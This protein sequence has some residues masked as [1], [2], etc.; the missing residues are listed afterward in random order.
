M[1][2]RP[3]PPSMTPPTGWRRLRAS[4]TKEAA[5]TTFAVWVLAGAL[6]GMTF[7]LGDVLVRL[8][9]TGWRPSGW[10]WRGHLGAA[11]PLHLSTG[12]VAGLAGWL[13]GRLEPLSG[14]ALAALTAHDRGQ[15]L[16]PSLAAPLAAGAFATIWVRSASFAPPA[17]LAA[18]LALATAAIMAPAAVVLACLL[19][20]WLHGRTRRLRSITAVAGLAVGAAFA[21]VDMTVLVALYPFLHAV[22]ELVTAA[23]WLTSWLLLASVVVERARRPRRIAAAVAVASAA[24]IVFLI[25]GG[26]RWSSAALRHTAKHKAYT[27]RLLAHGQQLAAPAPVVSRRTPH[28]EATRRSMSRLDDRS[29]DACP[30]AWW[31][32][33]GSMAPS[34]LRAAT[35]PHPNIVVFYV[36]TLRYDVATDPRVMPNVARFSRQSL[37]FTRAYATGS[38]TRSSLPAM[39]RG[40]YDF[41]LDDRHTLMRAAREHGL[42]TAVAIGKSPKVWLAKHIPHFKFDE[43][44]EADDADPDRKVW[45]YGANRPTTARLVDD[46]LAWLTRP[47]RKRFLLWQFHYDLHGWKEMND[48]EVQRRA[49]MHAIPRFASEEQWRYRVVAA[50]I[51]AEF[52]RFLREL[53]RTGLADETVVV[54]LADHGEG[55]GYQGFWLHAVFLWEGMV[56]VPL[57]VRVP[58]LEG[59]RV[60]TPVSVI[61]VAPTLVRMLDPGA[62]LLPY[63]GEDLL[64]QL[65]PEPPAR[66]YPL[67]MRSMVK[68]QVARLGVVAPDGRRKLVLPVESAQPELY[69]LGARLPD[70]LD[71]AER[72]PEVVDRLMPVVLEGAMNPQTR[73]KHQRCQRAAEPAPEP[74]TLATE[75]RRVT[76]ERQRVLAD[77]T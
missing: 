17:D 49:R 24:A 51:D 76:S 54:F 55:L 34:P 52:G 67:L 75:S 47:E 53:D 70:D 45:G 20:R 58:G 35:P 39:I 43:V 44:A 10:T 23:C 18:W 40:H 59:R 26:P 6:L 19:L 37:N 9:V 25:A 11:L 4:L 64:T 69:D 60:D 56:H 5:L 71:I 21:W 28:Q 68:E 42:R 62:S 31:P 32:T 77:P 27:G 22:A 36:D 61:D 63:H 41:G 14:A 46:S 72:E 57:M 15:R 38:D 66:R 3:A 33:E 12:I 50:S 30:D 74:D 13:V 1:M 7:A 2:T 73:R 8:G 48:D 29:D 16:L 65:D